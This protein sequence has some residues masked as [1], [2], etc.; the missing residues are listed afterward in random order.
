M[1][2]IAGTRGSQLALVQTELVAKALG[3]KFPELAV[4]QKIIKTLGDKKQGT[5]AA[6]QSDKRDW[7][8]ELEV[9]LLSGEIDFAVHSGKDVPHDINPTTLLIPVLKRSSP[10]D[11][12]IGKI[13]RGHQIKFDELAAGAVIGTASLRRKAFLL[14]I[15]PDLKV[16]EHRGN[17]PT[18]I[19][20]LEESEELSGIILASAGL[21]RLELNV[22]AEEIDPK[23]MVPGINQGI[24]TVQI[25]SDNIALREKLAGICDQHTKVA[26]EAERGCAKVLEGD[27]KSAIGIYAHVSAK[28]EVTLECAIM[29][30]DGSKIVRL[31]QSDSFQNAF[32]L[33]Q[34]VALKLLQNGGKK[35]LQ[36][37]K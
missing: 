23:L 30:H 28:E 34:N 35:I 16:V 2:L 6:S 3:L 20:K 24:L 27:C 32:A 4:T 36:E 15:R 13:S 37:C 25:K 1:K 5:K 29:S 17:V 9:A 7:V 26:F 19:K 18:R 10:H 31:V 21:K 11:V 8:H 14:R 33:G 12:F 22:Q